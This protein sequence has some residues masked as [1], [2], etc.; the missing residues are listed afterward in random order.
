MSDLD[1]AGI[2]MTARIRSELLE[3]K[4]LPRN[5]GRNSQKTVLKPTASSHLDNTASSSG[6]LTLPNQ[7]STLSGAAGGLAYPRFGMLGFKAWLGA[8]FPWILVTDYLISRLGLMA[9][10]LWVSVEHRT[11]STHCSNH[12]MCS[13]CWSARTPLQKGGN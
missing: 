9:E 10:L 7:I 8:L 6:V 1:Q 4:P 3:H 5:T 11:V 2:L 13:N 12:S